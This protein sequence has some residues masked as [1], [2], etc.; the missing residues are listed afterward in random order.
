MIA[1]EKFLRTPWGQGSWLNGITDKYGYEPV[2]DISVHPRDGRGVG[3]RHL[4]GLR[5]A[6][7]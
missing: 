2:A 1:P 5:L 7:S 3:G 4:V 6:R